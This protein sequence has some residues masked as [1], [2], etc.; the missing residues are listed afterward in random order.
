[1]Y[2]WCRYNM[3]FCTVLI[4]S[5]KFNKWKN[6]LTGCQSGSMILRTRFLCLNRLIWSMFISTNIVRR[7][8]PEFSVFVIASAKNVRRVFQEFSIFLDQTNSTD[9]SLGEQCSSNFSGIFFSFHQPNWLILASAK[10]VRRLF[11]E[12]SIFWIRLI[13][14]IP[15][16]ANNV[17]RFFQRNFRWDRVDY[18]PHCATSILIIE[19]PCYS[20][21]SSHYSTF[22]YY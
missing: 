2:R 8:F 20:W 15:V 5:E 19:Y 17:R 6:E 12:F 3:R 1:M 11:Q 10:N 18:P 21:S 9:T 14:L 13:R 22:L 4:M 16:L 7:T